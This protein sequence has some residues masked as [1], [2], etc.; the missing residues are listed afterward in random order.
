VKKR[1]YK[2]KAILSSF[3]TK[4]TIVVSGLLL[5]ALILRLIY[6]SH[7]KSNDPGFYEPPP[8]T[9]M[10]TYH[11]YAKAILNGTLEKEPYYYG[12]L[13]FYFLALIYKIFGIDLY[14]AR[15]IQMILGVSTSLLIYLIARKVFNKT[16]ALISLI[17]SIFYGMFYIHEG[18]LLMESLVTF[19]NTLAIFLLLRIEDNPSYKNIAFAGIAIGLSALARANILLFVPFI[20]IWIL[21][22]SK[23]KTKSLKLLKYAFLCLIILLTISPA[24]IRNYLVSG[25]FVLISTNGPINFWIGN[26]ENARGW[27]DGTSL[28]QDLIERIKEKGDKAYI[29]D[30]VNFIKRNPGG[31]LTLLFRKFLLFWSMDEISNNL[32]YDLFKA[33]SMLLRYFLFVGFWFIAP[34][35]LCGI[36]LSRKIW[37]KVVLLYLFIFSFMI[38]TII[39]FVLGRYRIPFIPFLIIFA[40]FAIWWWYEEFRRKRYKSLFSLILSFPFLVLVYFQPINNIFSSIL[41][42]EGKE[43]KKGAAIVIKDD[44]DD[45]HWGKAF[46]LYS[47]SNMVKKEL[48]IKK[49]IIKKIKKA[50]LFV[51]TATFKE[52]RL[53]VNINGRNIGSI[54]IENTNGKISVFTIEFDPKCLYYEKNFITV[55]PEE[56]G[57]FYMVIDETYTFRRSYILKNGKWEKLN[58][59]EFMIWL[60]LV[61]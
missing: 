3:L 45:W 23:L 59:G 49:G 30:V 58:K 24:T 51:R 48:F 42:S 37:K 43:V 39:F 47:P 13:Y 22:N 53:T 40:S 27:F 9:D 41:Y 7:L 15:L 46:V 19:L 56:N 60:E 20:F 31:Y 16:V 18:V 8:G 11:N 12:P 10:L 29:E 38:S 2:K 57:E 26:H 52:G 25:K 5:L 4:E 35:G 44:N 21:R 54:F 1:L 28:S 32:N 55:V 36:V 17:L 6:L 14:I 50:Y 33:Y 34:L 61:E